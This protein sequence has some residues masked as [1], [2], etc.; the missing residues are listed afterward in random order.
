MDLQGRRHLAK[1]RSRPHQALVLVLLLVLLCLTSATRSVLALAAAPAPD[2]DS[3]P[4]IEPDYSQEMTADWSA[5][6]AHNVLGNGKALRDGSRRGS[7]AVTESDTKDSSVRT[8][9]VHQ[10]TLMYVGALYSR[11]PP[12]NVHFNV[13]ARI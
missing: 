13:H 2:T 5:D 11:K 6:A 7:G 3:G 4:Y 9:C 12:I 1:A 10:C 8:D